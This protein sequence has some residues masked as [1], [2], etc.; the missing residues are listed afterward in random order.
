[1]RSIILMVLMIVICASLLA[2]P[3]QQET[4]LDPYINP[5]Y[6]TCGT[7]TEMIISHRWRYYAM[8][9]FGDQVNT[10]DPVFEFPSSPCPYYRPYAGYQDS[11][12]RVNC[13]RTDGHAGLDISAPEGTPIVAAAKGYVTYAGPFSR[14]RM[15]DEVDSVMTVETNIVN[16]ELIIEIGFRK[17]YKTGAGGLGYGNV[18][19]VYYPEWDVTYMY[20][21][22]QDITSYQPFYEEI[23]SP[24]QYVGDSVN[25]GEL[26]GYTGRTGNVP[27]DNDDHLHWEVL[28]GRVCMDASMPRSN[29]RENATEDPY[30]WLYHKS[31]PGRI[32][33][34]KRLTEKVEGGWLPETIETLEVQ[35]LREMTPFTVPPYT[36]GQ[37]GRTGNQMRLYFTYDYYFQPNGEHRLIARR[38]GA[39]GPYSTKTQWTVVW[40][41]ELGPIPSPRD[42]LLLSNSGSGS[43]LSISPNPFNSICRITGSA[44]LLDPNRKDSYSI[45]PTALV[46]DIQGQK[47]SRIEIENRGASYKIDWDGTDQKG[48]ELPSGAYFIRFIV[49]DKPQTRKV[50]LLK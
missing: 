7:E 22:A 38:V 4:R 23:T 44:D 45:G 26:V 14:G 18:I 5:W 16:G 17:Y 9:L 43:S 50:T 29:G 11:L 41:C 25:T 34:I 30:P 10:N 49:N 24:S 42:K 31:M 15:P 28:A 8:Y 37:S 40:G 27:E 12:G 13:N 39:V 46:Y 1:M 20:A 47:V 19:L 48:R 33:F 36:E 2:Q 35:A 6:T 3:G 32:A 21:H